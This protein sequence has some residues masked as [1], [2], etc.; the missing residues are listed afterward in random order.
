MRLAIILCLAFFCPDTLGFDSSH[1]LLRF[2]R[3]QRLIRAASVAT[4]GPGHACKI[5]R[6]TPPNGASSSS[7]LYG[8]SLTPP[9]STLSWNEDDSSDAS[10]SWDDVLSP[11][12]PLS[13]STSQ[14]SHPV[15]KHN[16]VTAYDKA[17]L[18][19]FTGLA[20]AAV[21]ILLAC[22]APGAWR[23]FLAGGI[24][25]AT[26]HAIPTP[27]DVIKVSACRCSGFF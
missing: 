24:C 18:A 2:Q 17:L 27:I 20:A 19:S 15:N 7:P 26:S 12:P 22:S 4:T 10:T 13:L 1:L 11:Q 25:A 16:A 21:G 6:R 23:Y 9:T 14:A 8:T 5:K 3:D